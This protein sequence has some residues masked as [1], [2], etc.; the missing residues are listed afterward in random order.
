MLLCKVYFRL[1]IEGATLGWHVFLEKFLE[2]LQGIVKQSEMRRGEILGCLLMKLLTSKTSLW[3]S[4]GY[5]SK[6][7]ILQ[8]SSL[9]MGLVTKRPRVEDAALLKLLLGSKLTGQS[10]SF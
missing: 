5:S 1:E 10:V 4:S 3:L 8:A 7:K 2:A 9:V 6:F